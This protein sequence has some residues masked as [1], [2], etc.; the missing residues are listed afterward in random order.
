MLSYERIINSSTKAFKKRHL[1]LDEEKRQELVKQCEARLG[2]GWGGFQFRLNS[3]DDFAKA[4]YDACGTDAVERFES[5][6]KYGYFTT[7]SSTRS[8]KNTLIVSETIVVTIEQGAR[9]RAIP[10]S[11]TLV[12]RDLLVLI[13]KKSNL[14]P[15]LGFEIFHYIA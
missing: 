12:G 15:H 14:L 10:N 6:R 13:E 9:R 7:S 1:I 5:L 11:W 4:L 3:N 8:K 2:Y